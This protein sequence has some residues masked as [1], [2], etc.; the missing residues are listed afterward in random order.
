MDIATIKHYCTS[1]TTA[2]NAAADVI[3]G[4]QLSGDWTVSHKSDQSPVTEVDVAAEVKIRS[5]LQQAHPDVS[6]FGE[7]TG[8]V[9]DGHLCWLVDPIDGTKSFVRGMRYFSTQI[10]LLDDDELI[11]GVSN[12][13]SYGEQLV[14]MKGVGVSL[15]G[16]PCQ[17]SGVDALHDVYL[18]TGNLTRLASQAD[19]WHQLAVLVQ[20]VK[21]VRGYGDF[22]HYHQLCSGQCDV[23][24]ES[25]VNILDI[26]AL[27][28]AIREAG[29][30]ITDLQGQ[31]VTLDTT[32]VLAAATP[33]LH[34]IVLELF[35]ESRW[36]G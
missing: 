33:T 2:V 32:S 9:G 13:P 25:D 19:S 5:V 27:T 16:V 18:S 4:F 35:N 34:D 8:K 3:S 31:P 6:F 24:V 23:V 22:T 20:S 29:G 11:V 21:R 28:V 14:A 12:A 30:V 36:S 17:T 1:A 15:N 7:E 10:A 26:A